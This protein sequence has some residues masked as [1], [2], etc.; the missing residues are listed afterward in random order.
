MKISVLIT[1]YNKE[2]L[3]EKCIESIPKVYEIIVCDDCSTDKSV[4]IVENLKRKELKLIKNKKNMGCNYTYNRCIDEATGDFIL[5]LDA[6]DYLLEDINKVIDIINK[7]K[8]EHDLYYYDLITNNNIRL[9]I[10]ETNQYDFGGNLK[11]IKRKFLGNIRYP[12][13]GIGDKCFT[14]EILD[15]KPKIYRTNELAYFYN[16]LE[17]GVM[18]NYCKGLDQ[19]ST[20]DE[21]NGQ[22][23]LGICQFH[24]CE[25]GGVETAV[26]NL[27]NQLKDWYDI[28]V[29]YETDTTSKEQIR[30]LQE[31]VK[32]ERIDF[33][34][35]YYF[36]YVLRDSIYGTKPNN[37]FSKSGRYMQR[38]HADYE[39]LENNCH[40]NYLKDKKWEKTT[41]HIACGE[42]VGKQF[43]K[44]YGIKPI[45][46]R[47]I[48]DDKRETKKIY[49]FV[50]AGRMTN[51]KGFDLV[52][53]F[54]SMTKEAGMLTEW[55]FITDSFTHFEYENMH[56]HC[57]TPRFDI[58]DYLAD[59]DY[60]LLLSKAEGLPYFIQECLQ[61]ETPVIVTDIGG[62]TEL[63]KDGVNGYVVPLD[64]N[65]DIN[66]I[67]KVPKVKDYDNGVNA[68]TW[69]NYIGGAV[70]KKKIRKKLEKVEETGFEFETIKKI[71]LNDISI[72]P[73]NRF[74][75]NYSERIKLLLNANLIKKVE[76]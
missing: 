24:F 17:D 49:R 8:G 23:T 68:K 43:K 74:K 20:P 13:K 62:C 16:K 55:T 39:W 58:F 35:V 21:E 73:G 29:L 42:Y 2:K 67:K 15:K 34:K 53:Q 48:M 70:Y 61:Y 51:D 25:V 30:R 54:M 37:V 1:L 76:E 14:R 45:V 50:L 66:K 64:L 12:L 41:E 38:L 47:N 71:K 10:N 57:L 56:I 44:M 4:E 40:M 65:F 60:G 63:I 36:D 22:K 46:I 27:C 33:D 3:I 75:A 11:F 31:I 18:S 72:E 52:K 7:T 32:V 9:S 19:F 5:I 6:D 69:C 59:A 28:T 26:Y